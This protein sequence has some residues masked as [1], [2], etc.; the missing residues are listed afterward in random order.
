MDSGMED[1]QNQARAIL[2][3]AK[4][5][6]EQ[7][8]VQATLNGDAQDRLA[9]AMLARMGVIGEDKTNINLQISV[10]GA[11]TSDVDEWSK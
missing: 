9:A 8:M 11:S 4:H 6:I 1:A 2:V 10:A 7:T 5:R 3:D